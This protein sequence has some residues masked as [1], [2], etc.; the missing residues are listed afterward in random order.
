[1]TVTRL[2]TKS[3]SN[4]W[5]RFFMYFWMMKYI[6]T[7]LFEE[8]I[9]SNNF[10]LKFLCSDG[11]SYFI[12]IIS[13]KT[14]HI[15]LIYEVIGF[16]LANHFNLPIPEANYVTIKE[17]SFDYS[18][19][20]FNNNVI[21]PDIVGF[22]SREIKNHQ[23]IHPSIFFI[24]SKRD[25]NMIL[26]P[27]DFIKIGIFDFY[28][29]NSDRFEGN[30]NLIY[31]STSKGLKNKIFAID[32][33]AIFCNPA[34]HKSFKPT[35]A[36]NLTKNILNS[37]IGKKIIHYY[38]KENKVDYNDVI[39]DFFTNN[40]EGIPQLINKAFKT[41]PS[42]WTYDESLNDR[43]SEY[44]LN[45]KRIVHLQEELNVFFRLIKNQ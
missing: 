18:Q 42:C 29:S 44:L 32:Q 11:N 38:F 37:P 31:Q 7:W 3:V 15:D 25:Y 41:L 17:N 36:D 34:N 6:D 14:G 33:V 23:I 8:E 21:N 19:I 20:K 16:H 43:I 1:M 39:H 4:R 12:K 2:T 24:N 30:Y 27:L 40:I 10:P 9:Q 28:I 35:T 22:G 13:T 5:I 26:N 45:E